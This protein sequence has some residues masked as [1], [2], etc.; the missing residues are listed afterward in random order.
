MQYVTHHREWAIHISEDD[1]HYEAWKTYGLKLIERKRTGKRADRIV[2]H[3]T[4]L[5]QC[6]LQLDRVLDHEKRERKLAREN[7][8]KVEQQ[9][10]KIE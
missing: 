7:K 2:L 6:L 10:L 3:G 5:D 1:G 4:D 8:K 9:Q